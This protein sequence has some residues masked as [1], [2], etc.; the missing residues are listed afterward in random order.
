M[1]DIRTTLTGFFT[2]LYVFLSSYFG[3]FTPLLVLTVLAM[4]SDLITRVYA[5]G[6][7]DVEK[8]ESKKVMK[9]IYKKL[10]M[11]MLICLTLILD[12]G[13]MLIAETLGINVATKI[14]FTAFTLAW[15]FVRELI[16][17]LENLALAGIEL[18]KF[19][20]KALNLAKDKIDN[21]ADLNVGGGEDENRG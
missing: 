13:L 11:C 12:S 14:I 3:V 20:V 6:A 17:N 4:F 15:I 1:H 21:T 8:V 9:G 19:I 7:S 10:G 16:S 2:A 5:A 18:P